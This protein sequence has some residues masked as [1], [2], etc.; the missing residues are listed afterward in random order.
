MAA[1][2]CDDSEE[3]QTHRLPEGYIDTLRGAGNAG[4]IEI[5]LSNFLTPKQR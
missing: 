5:A 3:R 4:C 1:C 2:R